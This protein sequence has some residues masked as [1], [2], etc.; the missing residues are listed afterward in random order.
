[1]NE[2]Q[3]EKLGERIALFVSP[4]YAAAVATLIGAVII[5]GLVFAICL[6]ANGQE[7]PPPPDIYLWSEMPA[8]APT[9][10]EKAVEQLRLYEQYQRDKQDS[11]RR[12]NCV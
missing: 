7:P 9:K 11:R 12:V 6:Q 1:M 5:I 2:Q 8:H 4:I 10:M 3:A